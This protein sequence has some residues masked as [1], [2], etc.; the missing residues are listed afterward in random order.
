VIIAFTSS[1]K[2]S[3][4][5]A[6]AIAEL[7]RAGDLI[8]LAG[9]LG[10]GKT[11]FA[12]GFGAALGITDRITSPTFTLVNQYRGRL[13]LNHL[14]VYRLDQVE[15]VLDLGL[16]EMLDEGGVTLIEWGDTVIPALPADY[17]EVRLRLGEGDDDRVFE[18]QLVGPRWSAR[19]RAL[20]TV[21]RPW[22][23][24]AAEMPQMRDRPDGGDRTD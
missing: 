15:E 2:E 21:L 13:E 20:N 5:L 6:A 1:A 19:S 3:S 16:A 17:L 9:D 24:E 12:Q 7:V 23:G 22:L 18:I 8:L 14:D 4:L 11:T 10:A